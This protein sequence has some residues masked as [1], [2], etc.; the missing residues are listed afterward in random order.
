M[1]D[2]EARI[3]VLYREGTA[4]GVAAVILD[5]V[6]GHGSH[7]DPAGSLA[8]ACA[9]IHDGGR[10]PVVVAYVLGTLADPQGLEAQ[11]ATLAE[12]GCLVTPTAARA[13][14]AAAALA[15][16]SAGL[17]GLAAT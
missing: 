4:P 6:L 5:V 9:G 3:E 7:R 10:G 13:S 8:P 12:A 11:R 1:I 2:P 14:L 16:R 17:V 15:T